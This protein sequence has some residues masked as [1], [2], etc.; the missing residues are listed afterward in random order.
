MEPVVVL[1]VD[2]NQLF[3]EGLKHAL[4]DT[5]FTV[6]NDLGSFVEALWL[7]QTER[8]AFDFVLGGHAANNDA[9]FDAIYTIRQQ[10]PSVKIVLLTDRGTMSER[11]TIMRL[12]TALSYGVAG[13][14]SKY[15]SAQALRHALELILI[16]GL[17]TPITIIQRPP[18]VPSSTPAT[19][20][21][22]PEA[23]RLADL[24]DREKQILRCLM[25]GLPNKLIARTLDVSEPTV[26]V[27]LRALLRKLNAQNRTQAA[28][29]AME[30]GAF[31][32]P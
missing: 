8:V 2:D 28:V 1:L 30:N 12:E 15:I 9:E 32:E 24:T 7:M 11:T 29:W 6:R 19:H 3:R 31:S 4:C 17:V 5:R 10:F 21:A 23:E 26:K 16:G 22:T 20:L 27:H 25:T 14:L 13:C 18:L